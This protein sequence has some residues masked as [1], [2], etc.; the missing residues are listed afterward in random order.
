MF[1]ILLCQHKADG[2]AAIKTNLQ[3]YLTPELRQEAI[4]LLEANT[5]RKDA[6]N[7]VLLAYPLPEN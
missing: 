5:G 3:T 7:F 1:P 6:K 4:K 2:F